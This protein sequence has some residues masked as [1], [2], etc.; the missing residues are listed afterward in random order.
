MGY[1]VL[2]AL[3]GRRN[4]AMFQILDEW[5]EFWLDESWT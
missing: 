5:D 4:I 2:M 1:G 3:M